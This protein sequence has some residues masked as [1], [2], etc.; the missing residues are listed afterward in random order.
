MLPAMSSPRVSGILLHPTSLPGRYGIGDLGPDADRWI[1][2][3]VAAGQRLWQILPL[4]PTGYGNSPYQC[5]SAF[6]GNPWLVSPDR[7][8][9]EGLVR[10]DELERVP[11]FPGARVD[12]GGVIAWKRALLDEASERF[13]AGAGGRA[14]R[15]EFD[16]FRVEHEDW[17]DDYALFMAIK[18]EYDLVAWNEW[19]APLAKRNPAALEQA[20]RRLERV[21]DG[22]RLQQFLFF[23]QW[24]ALRALAHRHG[25]DVLGDIPI[26][27]AYDSA[28]VW[29]HRE[30]FRLDISGRPTAVAGVPP[31]YFSRTGQLWGN[32]LYRW[33]VLR[34][35]GYAWWIQRFRRTLALVDRVRLDHFRG[36]Q[37]Y[38]AVPAGHATAERGRWVR[39]PGARFFDVVRSAIGHLP[40]VA[41]D[42][43]EITPDVH[44]MRDRLGL[45]GMKILQFAFS[46]DANDPFLPHRFTPHCV[47]YTGTHDND[48]T[49]GWYE[50]SSTPAERDR[51]RQ[52]LGRDGRDIAWDLIR[53]AQASVADT[54]VVPLQDVLDLGTDARMNYPGRE[55]DNWEWRFEWA[56][57]SDAHARRLRQL[58]EIF[59][60]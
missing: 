58:T 27:V 31:D 33:D 39:G 24:T 48:T 56:Q 4:G 41:E 46:S 20:R 14:L 52:Y 49:R 1:E 38:W 43:G 7:L 35:D 34:R 60:R 6:A 17:L 5:F 51:A 18:E 54:A 59:G 9:D 45:P 13:R 11:R 32:P 37:A 22:H 53:L 26:F 16:A 42:L 40:I 3:L 10:P 15:E 12:Y 30:L 57:L 2:F 21:V 8:R 44:A 29:A 47:A 55:A 36:F 23:R 50:H 28:D 19:P 25:V